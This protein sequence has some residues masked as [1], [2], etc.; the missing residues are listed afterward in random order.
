MKDLSKY[1]PKVVNVKVLN[2]RKIWI[3]NKKN[4]KV[5]Q[6]VQNQWI[7]LK[8]PNTTELVFNWPLKTT[9][10]VKNEFAKRDFNDSKIGFLRDRKSSLE[11]QAK[12]L[13][14]YKPN[15]NL[16]TKYNKLLVKATQFPYDL[17]KTY[18]CDTIP[19]QWIKQGRKSSQNKS[20]NHHEIRT[21]KTEL[22]SKT[23]SKN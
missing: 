13:K 23:G 21:C 19:K 11:S 3:T 1:C 20:R 10:T 6:I 22:S 7:N 9:N 4:N 16:T 15:Q 17:N 12:W 8:T 5:I 18:T 14:I 2:Q